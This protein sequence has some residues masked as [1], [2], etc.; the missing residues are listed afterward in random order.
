MGPLFW[1]P[2]DLGGM[3]RRLGK[4]VRSRGDY[5]GGGEVRGRYEEEDDDDVLGRFNKA[6]GA[7]SSVFCGAFRLVPRRLIFMYAEIGV[8][9]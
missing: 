9:C 1:D 3:G 2:G 4:G 7:S 6:G 5:E 8:C